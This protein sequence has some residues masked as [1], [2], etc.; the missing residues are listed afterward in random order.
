MIRCIYHGLTSPYFKHQPSSTLKKIKSYFIIN[1]EV[2]GNRRKIANE[3]NNYFISI[4]TK[5]NELS[6]AHEVGV[7]ITNFSEYFNKKLGDSMFMENC[8]VN[9]VAEIIDD[10]SNN[11][12]SDIP[13]RVLKCCSHLISGS[14]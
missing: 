2:V 7:P 8:T 12:A 5:L 4:V 13:V 9:E 6:G 14:L 1:G 10:L 3:F 11:K